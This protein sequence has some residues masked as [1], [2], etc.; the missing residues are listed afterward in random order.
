MSC[1]RRSACRTGMPFSGGLLFVTLY[2]L[3]GCWLKLLPCAGQQRVSVQ[4][5]QATGRAQLA[6]T[7]PQITFAFANRFEGLLAGIS[8]ETRRSTK[9]CVQSAESSLAVSATTKGAEQT[10]DHKQRHGGF[11]KFWSALR[12][13]Q[14]RKF[15][16]VEP[17]WTEWLGL[18][19]H[20]RPNSM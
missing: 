3:S 4:H 16:Q 17:L 1:G 12:I 9:S 19:G 18:V 7:R 2:L 8:N 20:A 5:A 13:L 11:G 14:A 10:R 6:P 15:L